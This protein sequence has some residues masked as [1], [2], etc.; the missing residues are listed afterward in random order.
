MSIDRINNQIKELE[1]MKLQFQ[2][3]PQ[4]QPT[5]TPSINQTFQLA[6]NSQ[7]AGVRYAQD[8]NEVQKEFVVGD[9]PFFD[10]NFSVMW[11]KNAK[12]EIKSYELKEIVERDEKDMIIESLQA[13]LNDLKKGLI[14]YAKP[15][16]SNDD[17][18]TEIE[19]PT[20]VRTNKSSKSK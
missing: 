19:K 11:L 15:N 16:N 1:N 9:T 7:N 17:G 20:N 14:E 2:N 18:T 8:I 4:Q 13:Q 5:T 12:G 6:P 3:V 10:K